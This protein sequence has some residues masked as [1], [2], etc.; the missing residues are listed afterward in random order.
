MLK[1]ST[2]NVYKTALDATHH[3]SQ[4]DTVAPGLGWGS[5]FDNKFCRSWNFSERERESGTT[6]TSTWAI[7]LKRV[8]SLPPTS[9]SSPRCYQGNSLNPLLSMEGLPGR[10]CPSACGPFLLNLRVRKKS[11]VRL[12]VCEHF[13][14]SG[15]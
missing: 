11:E 6:G 14:D 4:G 2:P 15:A 12:W 5:H 1:Q 13:N 7:L 8:I 10:H 3:S 9:G